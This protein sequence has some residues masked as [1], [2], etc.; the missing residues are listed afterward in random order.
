MFVILLT[1]A[2]ARMVEPRYAMRGLTEDGRKDVKRAAWRFRELVPEIDPALHEK[3]LVIGKIVS[4]PLARCLETVIVFAKELSD[5]TKTSEIWVS[6]RL[7]EKR[8]EQLTA[9]D[10]AAVVD[11]GEVAVM[12]L[13]THGDL[14]GALPCSAPLD[15]DKENSEGK[16]LI[17]GAWFGPRPVLVL[18]E[19]EPGVPWDSAQ[20]LCCEY[21]N[22]STWESLLEA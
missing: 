16:N 18:V 17:Q 15:R 1:H 8:G 14:A 11:E 6:E 4:S 7:R 10:L 20:V 19:H 5:F 2:D 22:G 9:D 3:S 13:G 12:L 21:F